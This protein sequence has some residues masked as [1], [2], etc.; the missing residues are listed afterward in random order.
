MRLVSDDTWRWSPGP[1]T[2]SNV[3]AGEEKGLFFFSPAEGKWSPDEPRAL[4]ENFTARFR[5][6]ANG[7][8]DPELNPTY[9]DL[10][11]HYGIAVIPARK[12]KP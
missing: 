8:Y 4:P 3:Y 12:R 5:G 1:V 11:Q 10:A 2:F 6:Q 7:F 9:A